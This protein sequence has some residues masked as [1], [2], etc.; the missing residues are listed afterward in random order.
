MSKKKDKDMQRYLATELKL[1]IKE[2]RWA[3][4]HLINIYNAIRPADMK[5]E[6]PAVN[7]LEIQF[8][9]PQKKGDDK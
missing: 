8:P 5:R 6:P 2:S 3:L 9:V 7:Q 1:H 4:Q